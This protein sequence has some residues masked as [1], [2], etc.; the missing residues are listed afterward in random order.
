MGGHIVDDDDIAAGV[1]GVVG[2]GGRGI[3]Q[4]AGTEDEHEVGLGGLVPGFSQGLGGQVFTEK[5]DIGLERPAAATA[6]GQGA[7]FD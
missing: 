2:Q 4:K 5:S 3:D 7:G 1:Q 6:A